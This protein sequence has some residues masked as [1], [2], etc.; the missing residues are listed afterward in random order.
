VHIADLLQ[1]LCLHDQN[2]YKQ[3]KENRIDNS[4]GLLRNNRES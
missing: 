1:I 2:V 4:K 3:E